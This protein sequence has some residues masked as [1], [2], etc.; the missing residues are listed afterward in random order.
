[1]N[2][3]TNYCIFKSAPDLFFIKV[4]QHK[5]KNKEN[6]ILPVNMIYQLEVNVQN[7]TIR[8]N[9]ISSETEYICKKT[10]NRGMDFIENLQLFA[11][12]FMSYLRY[13][14]LFMHS[15]VQHILCCVFLIGLLS[16]SCVWW[17]P[18]YI[19]L[20]FLLVFVLCTQCCHFRWIVQ[21]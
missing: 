14:C 13:M 9:S 17:C 18:T 3:N 10:E 5:M 2:T 16:S 4:R 19:V 21:F 15:G 1:V 8:Q 12:V 7:I 20:C 11:E 6:F